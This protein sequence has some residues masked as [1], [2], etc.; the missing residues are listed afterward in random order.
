[1]TATAVWYAR[2]LRQMSVA[3]VLARVADHSRRVTWRRYCVRPD[4]GPA[5]A[6][7]QRAFITPLPATAR[8][9]VPDA[10]AREAIAAADA[11][12]G[13]AWTVLG[14]ARPD[15]A[16]PDWFF[17]PSTGRRAP[18]DRFAFGIDYRDERVTGNVKAVWELSRH[19]HLT[20]LAGAYW[21]TGDERYA[22]AVAAQ[23]QSWWR[24][25]AFLSGIHWTSGIE[26]AVRLLSWVWIRRLLDGWHGAADLFEHNDVAVRQVWWHQRFL[27]AFPSRGSSANNHL[28]AEAAGQVA[29]ACAFAWF[30]QS[31]SW[32]RQAVDRLEEAFAANTFGDGVNRELATDY[33]RFVT[34]LVTLAAV[35]AQAAGTP[36][37]TSTWDRLVKS[38]DAAA[39]LV[40]VDCRPPRQGDGDEGRALLVDA[41]SA[42]PWSALLGVGA[43]TVG[44]C[45]WWPRR[46]G[47]VLAAVIDGLLE[48]AEPPTVSRPGQGQGR[49]AL[50]PDHF[51]EAGI[52]LLRTPPGAS[53]E[54]WCRC[55]GGPHGFLSIAAHAHAD[56][57]SVEFR[58]DG[59]EVLADPGTYCYHGEP[60]WRGYFRST[61]AHNT[62]VIDG[63]DQSVAGGPFMWTTRAN[64]TG[65]HVE[66]GDGRLT[67]WRAEHS[68]Y[69]RLD[70]HLLHERQVDLDPASG[71]LTI[72]DRI[73]SRNAHDADL[74]F[75]LGPMVA[76][77]L[78]GSTALLS[79]PARSARM[80]A[81]MQLPSALRWT[82]H[83]GE[84]DPIAGWYSP[85][86]GVRVPSS[87]LVG[88]GTVHGA[89]TL[90]TSL[91]IQQLSDAR[92][93]DD[94]AGAPLSAPAGGP[95]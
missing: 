9:A 72:E 73:S 44:G 37:S 4:H 12:L 27:A 6:A 94:V 17:D 47:G 28:I 63:A 75:H 33:H 92:G 53:P 36:L 71:V 19:H 90:V 50:R 18:A 83:R 11:I 60:E 38:F 85:A 5:R 31:G 22:E 74:V 29:A 84:R 2:R 40:D 95:R 32:Q 77:N 15:I 26:L 59:V 56:A 88:S 7:R 20:V 89:L 54:L 14:S 25:N 80:N 39:A 62:V 52:T 61:R 13:G 42:N 35:E 23:L 3:E 93:I 45:D 68:G 76:V 16:D 51:P 55:D 65:V 30:P 67:A 81:V 8:A 34:E 64:T 46:D 10:A 41:P 70:D 69:R 43:A 58:H 86:F 1:M 66:H 24:C 79:W 91:C 87:T 57:L 49:P 48:A 78:V 21:L 82:Q